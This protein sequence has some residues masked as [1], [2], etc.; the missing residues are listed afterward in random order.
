MRVISDCAQIAREFGFHPIKQLLTPGIRMHAPKM[1]A[2][3]I[4]DRNGKRFLPPASRR[5]AISAPTAYQP[6]GSAPSAPDPLTRPR[7]HRNSP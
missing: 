5:P 2:P 6:S 7:T 1:V 4:A 3:V